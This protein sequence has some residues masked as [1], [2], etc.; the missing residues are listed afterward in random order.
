MNPKRM[1][2]FCCITIPLSIVFLT[3]ILNGCATRHFSLRNMT[4]VSRY[5]NKDK[6]TVWDAVTQALAG[7]PIETTD[8]EQGLLKTQWVK[9][10]LAKKTTGLLTEGEWQGRYR[11]FIQVSEVE[12]KTY[13]SIRAQTEE[14]APGGSQAYRWNRVVSDGTIE[15]DFLKRIENILDAT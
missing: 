12:D 10:W 5:F 3:V 6:N 8:M 15:R 1:L 14:K 11:L 7:I 4:D 13:V 9:G 2:R